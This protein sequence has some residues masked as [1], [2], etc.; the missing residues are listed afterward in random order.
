MTRRL[1]FLS[2]VPLVLLMVLPACGGGS[3]TDADDTGSPGTGSCTTVSQN[4]FV[5]DTLQDIY[6]WY[7][8]LPNL[9]PARSSSP[10]AYL[11]AVR[12][13]ALDSSFSYITGKAADTAFYSDSQFIGYG[14]SSVQTSATDLRLAQVFP[15]SPASEI[16]LQRGDFLLTVNGRS[17]P[18]LIRTGETSSI[19]GATEIGVPA[20][21]T[22]RRLDGI[23]GRGTMRKRLVT[24]PTVSDTR[25]V[26][27]G[28][29]RVGY[30]HFRNFVTPSTAAL[31]TAFAHAEGRGSERA[32]AGPPVQRRR[33]RERGPAPGWAHRRRAHE[34]RS[35]RGVLPQ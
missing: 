20:D 21:V 31:N 9:D 34:Q 18:D 7:R 32:R 19:F 35:V 24:I 33:A 16:G 14:I 2:F 28:G 17:V 23:E 13:K 10:E 29:Q 6:F 15:D 1:H 11:E 8:E 3:P 26:A 12:Y 27:Q 30:L 25:V 5:R 22:W 4:T